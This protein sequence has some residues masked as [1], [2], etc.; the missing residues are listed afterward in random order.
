MRCVYCLTDSAGTKSIAHVLP[1]AIAR[2]DLV[3][4]RGAVCDACNH[5]LG[6]ELDSV[7]VATL[8]CSS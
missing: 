3:L 6:H 5:Y 7:M 8:C 4:P 2:N 1:E